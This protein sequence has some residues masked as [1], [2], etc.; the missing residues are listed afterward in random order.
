MSTTLAPH[1]CISLFVCPCVSS[2]REVK[3]LLEEYKRFSKLVGKMGKLGLA[4]GGNDLNQVGPQH[5]TDPTTRS[6]ITHKEKSVGSF[7]CVVLCVCSKCSVTRSRC[8]PRCS[9]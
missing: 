7:C 2:I 5:H 6:A 1:L 4:K 8:W 3:E 9:R